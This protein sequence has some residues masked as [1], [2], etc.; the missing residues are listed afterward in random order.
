MMASFFL[1][2][3]N[4]CKTQ[5]QRA[6]AIIARNNAPVHVYIQSARLNGKP[7][8]R[9]YLRHSE[10][11]AGGTLELP[12]GAARKPGPGPLASPGQPA[13]LAMG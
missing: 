3:E 8:Q 2:H 6:F 1:R 11:T 4:I 13:E 10:I 7:L 12:D 5:K 9:R